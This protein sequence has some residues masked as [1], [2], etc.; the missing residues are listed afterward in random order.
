MEIY[1]GFKHPQNGYCIRKI[2]G[3]INEREI[4]IEVSGA[5]EKKVKDLFMSFKH[6][7]KTQ[8][9]AREIFSYAFRASII[10]SFVFVSTN[11]STQRQAQQ[12][13]FVVAISALFVALVSLST[14]CVCDLQVKRLENHR[15]PIERKA[16]A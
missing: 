6:L 10:T 1:S 7:E 8:N 12:A 15:L 5:L 13:S 14:I 4:M 2:K 11:I 3:I 16:E 9:R